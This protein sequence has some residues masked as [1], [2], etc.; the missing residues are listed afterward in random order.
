MVAPSSLV[1][2][3]SLLRNY[4]FVSL[5]ELLT[6]QCVIRVSDDPDEFFWNA[7]MHHKAPEYYSAFQSK[8][9]K[10]FLKS[11]KFK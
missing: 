4:L 10:A 3:L 11:T 6:G 8:L 2:H 9:L 5:H 1:L 7:T